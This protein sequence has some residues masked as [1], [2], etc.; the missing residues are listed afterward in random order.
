MEADV[1]GFDQVLGLWIL[2]GFIV[3]GF[4]IRD[5]PKSN[6]RRR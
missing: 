1:N 4:I 2:I 5:A 3:R 6:K